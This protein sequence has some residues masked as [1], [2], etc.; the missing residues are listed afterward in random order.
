MEVETANLVRHALMRVA[1]IGTARSL[2]MSLPNAQPLAGKTGTSNDN[3]DSWFVG[4]GSDKLGVTWVGRDDNSSTG[5]TGGSGALPIWAAIMKGT[6]LKPIVDR[7][8]AK[9]NLS[10][11]DLVSASKIP[12]SCSNG[13][14]VPLH[15]DSWIREVSDCDS[16][17]SEGIFSPVASS[18]QKGKRSILDRFKSFFD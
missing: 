14:L 18:R 15:S 10:N 8:S 16:A 6:V 17:A 1:S 11:I 4:F 2:K 13:E 12:V 5:L 9:I 7:Y 3:R